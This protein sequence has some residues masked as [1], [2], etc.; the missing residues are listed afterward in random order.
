MR[1]FSGGNQFF[2]ESFCNSLCHILLRKS[3]LPDRLVKKTKIIV[4]MQRIFFSVPSGSAF[5]SSSSG[6]RL[7]YTCFLPT[8]SNR[9]L[10]PSST[11]SQQKFSTVSVKVI[12]V[13]RD[14]TGYRSPITGRSAPRSQKNPGKTTHPQDKKLV[15]LVFFIATSHSG[16][17]FRAGFRLH[18]ISA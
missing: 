14:K 6:I 12:P 16:Q 18:D 13:C 5:A 4:P 7:L 15:P 3:G 11:S 2:S 1:V 8:H 9:A 17:C 10:S